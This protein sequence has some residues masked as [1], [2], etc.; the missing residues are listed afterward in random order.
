M[1]SILPQV[2]NVGMPLMVLRRFAALVIYQIPNLPLLSSVAER[3]TEHQ[4]LIRQFG[5]EK[6]TRP[7]QGEI[8]S[9]FE[10][11]PRQ[12]VTLL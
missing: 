12:F 1:I 4:M 3:G 9:L 6:T 5:D 11:L 7:A 2:M 8:F 10:Y